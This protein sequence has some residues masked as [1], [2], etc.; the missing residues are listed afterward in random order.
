[1]L[2]QGLSRDD[3]TREMCNTW[4]CDRLIA[5]V[6]LSETI[7]A[8]V[9][10]ITNWPSV[11]IAQDDLIWK[12]PGQTKTTIGYHQD[13]TYIS[14]QFVPREDN[15]VTVWIALDDVTNDMG[16]VEYAVGSHLWKDEVSG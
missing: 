15:S 13:G 11:R 2:R 5:S 12:P 7:G 14:N 4:K 16:C 8:M 1:M 9:A 6:I 3:V 10:N